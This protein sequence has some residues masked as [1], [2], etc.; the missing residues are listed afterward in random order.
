MPL[1]C[2]LKKN[3]RAIQCPGQSLGGCTA[4]LC[5]SPL[6]NCGLF[7]WTVYFANYL[8]D[9]R[10]R[11]MV[12]DFDFE[13][14]DVTM[15]AN[16]VKNVSRPGGGDG[17]ILN[18]QNQNQ[19]FVGGQQERIFVVNVSNPDVN[20]NWWRQITTGARVYHVIAIDQDTIVGSHVEGGATVSYSKLVGGTLP[21]RSVA[22]ILPVTGAVPKVV[23]IIPVSG[24][25]LI[26]TT[27]PEGGEPGNVGFATISA[28]ELNT[29]APLIQDVRAHNG[30]F[31]ASAG[32]LYLWGRT[33]VAQYDLA[34]NLV[35]S[36]DVASLIGNAG[37]A[38]ARHVDNGVIFQDRW[39]LIAV[40]A[41]KL[42]WFD[43]NGVAALSSAR[44][45]A[46]NVTQGDE[47]DSI[48]VPV[49]VRA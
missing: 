6:P 3:A 9:V 47:L 14:G 10:V 42:L 25:R 28:T 22:T 23:S 32:Q 43:L 44:S 29:Q 20:T 30:V 18:P 49:C 31:R 16:S 34:G 11:K 38:G 1:T 2:G 36:V 39:L 37:T 21:D 33:T 46:L 48:T 40:N 27:S 17:I 41:G 4:P 45:G 26:Y 8:N 13:S 19:L 15:R 12:L 5:C 35:S 7:G 24:G